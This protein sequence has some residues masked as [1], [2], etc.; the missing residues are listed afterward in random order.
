MMHPW[1]IRKGFVFLMGLFLLAVSPSAKA[2]DD[3]IRVT[4]VQTDYVAKTLTITVAD[5]DK[6]K[7]LAAPKVRLAGSPLVILNSVVHNI[8]HTGVVTA[9]LPSPVP[10]G[11]FLLEGAWGKHD[12]DR[13]HTFSL[14]F[15]LLRQ[16][17]PTR[18]TAHPR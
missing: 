13:E 17:G 2:D 18:P 6:P 10:P 11:S 15:S 12:D 5:L 16:Q 7:H 9:N 14:A 8:A 1:A 4:Q 3:R